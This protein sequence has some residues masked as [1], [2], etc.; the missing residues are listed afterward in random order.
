VAAIEI[1]NITDDEVDRLLYRHEGHFLDFKA[2]E[3]APAKLSKSISAFANADGGE[4]LI[5]ANENNGLFQWS[6]FNYPEDAN[7]IIQ[8]VQNICPLGRGVDMRFLK[9]ASAG[10]VLQMDIH[11]VRE[12]IFA[13]DKVPYI[14]RSAQNVAVT[15]PEEL[16]RLRLDKGIESYETSTIP[17]NVVLIA[18]ST[19]IIGFILEIVPHQEP[20]IWLTK[21]QLIISG[22]PTVAGA[23][24]FA[25]LPQALIPKQCGI[26]IYRYKS[27]EDEGTRDTLVGQPVTVE[28]YA[29]QQIYDA[30]S[31]TKALIE[32]IRRMTPGGLVSVSY[33]EET[34]HEIITN[35][36]LHRDYSIA[37]DVHI[38]VY[39][40]RVEIES[41]G[42][43]PGHVTIANILDT[44][45]ARNGNIV[46]LINK[47]PDPPNKDIGEGL[48]TAF[49]AM[50]KLQLKKPTI[51]QTRG[52]VLVTIKHERLGSAEDLIVTFLDQNDT[53]NNGQAREL[54]VI[55]EDWR[56]RKIFADLVSA[57]M[58]E[59]VEGS[60]T[61]NTAYRKK[62]VNS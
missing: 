44:R 57:G 54:C 9:S 14:R 27:S 29:Y 26:K 36:V 37:D 7:A 25:D 42:V 35:A 17:A 39:D 19:A 20:E 30:V 8:V 28:G 4:L 49:R 3:I 48:N 59:K 32:S 13:T 6:G 21:Q 47:F 10:F 51:E 46:R 60:V 56:I 16:Q 43:L 41:P 55:R 53:I 12:I 22:K 15:S 52:S 62:L 34:L 50:E 24:L 38:R 31:Q 45:F 2:K 58:I 1:F 61:S 5:G 40:N 23:V 18:N 33:P 11:K